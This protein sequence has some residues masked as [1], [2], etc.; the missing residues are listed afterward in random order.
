MATHPLIDRAAAA[1]RA[2]PSA[3]SY[4]LDNP[5]ALREQAEKEFR[6]LGIPLLC[7]P[8]LRQWALDQMG[9]QI[10][11]AMADRDAA[12]PARRKGR[13]AAS[14]ERDALMLAAVMK[15]GGL[16][17]VAARRAA[18]KR[19]GVTE[20]Q[21]EKAEGRR[22]KHLERLALTFGRFEGPNAVAKAAADAF[23]NVVRSASEIL[24]EIAPHPRRT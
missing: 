17:S 20:D 10:V 4:L 8:E 7:A 12:S 16:G 5:E 11:L 19:L 1:W 9:R 18:A 13:P 23:A 15:A 6:R 3:L 22:A 24:D 21:I 14:L 2:E